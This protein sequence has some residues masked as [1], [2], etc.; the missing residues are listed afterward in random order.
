MGLVTCDVVSTCRGTKQ[1]KGTT[2]Q[3]SILSPR[4]SLLMMSCW[5]LSSRFFSRRLRDLQDSVNVSETTVQKAYR[6][7]RQ[8][9]SSKDYASSASSATRKR[10]MKKKCK[11]SVYVTKR[12]SSAQSLPKTRVSRM[13][14][15]SCGYQRKQTVSCAR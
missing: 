1:Y 13:W 10:K 3:T 2:G 6:P 8:F 11:F 5:L 4:R 12:A 9:L 7:V 15:I 14:S